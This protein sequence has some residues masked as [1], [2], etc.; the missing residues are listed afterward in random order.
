MR[1][2]RR[3]PRETLC[4]WLAAALAGLA[5]GAALAVPSFAAQTG[6]P[7]N[8]CHVG[9]FGPQ[10]TPFGRNF[11]MRGYTLR[12][13]D[14][15][16]PL[17]AFATASYLRTLKDQ[18]GPP[19]PSFKTNDNLAV[20]QISLF[21]AG[22]LGKH[23]GAFVQNTYDGVAKAF[24]WDNLD[25]RAVTTAKVGRTEAVFGLSLNNNPTVQDSFNTLAA[26]GFPYTTSALAP[27][28]AAAPLVGNLAQNTLGLTGYTWV[29]SEIYAE[30]G[31]YR[32]LGAGFLTHAGVSPFTPGSIDGVAPYARLAY[33]KNFGERNFELGAFWMNAALF[34][35]R[36]QSTGS[37]DQYADLGLDA[38]LQYFAAN[39]DVF[40]VN[41]IY[42]HERQRLDASRALGLASNDIDSLQQA[43]LD[44]SY[45]WRNRVGLTAQLF[46]TWGSRDNL[47]Y[48]ANRTFRPDSSGLTLQ[49]D[50]TP[51]GDGRSPLGRRFNVR[52]GVQYTAY[53]TFDGAA[54][55]F[56]GLGRNAS[57]NNTVRVF[58]WIYY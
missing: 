6:Q 51:Y 38:S 23:F 35:G 20:D 37:T 24:H 3:W 53:F 16:V 30:F 52:M 10:L 28:P 21:V 9:G 26:W 27:H 13:V 36:D 19:A 18:P 42:T 4:A 55:N 17:A 32:S 2:L 44:A 50:G 43:R 33:Q 12:A 25:V 1:A 48:G 5:P 11:K 47:L 49:L 15:N 7:C 57:D 46:D 56:D 34:P 39:R 45:Y 29:N 40:T 31:G 22:G 58:T 14:F 41:G 8:T 54:R